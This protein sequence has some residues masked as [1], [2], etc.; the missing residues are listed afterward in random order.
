[1][2][3][4]SLR[5]KVVDW[6]LIALAVLPLVGIIVLKILFAPPTEGISVSVPV[7]IR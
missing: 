4:K 7:E 6:L 1:M 3:C 5:F 2:D